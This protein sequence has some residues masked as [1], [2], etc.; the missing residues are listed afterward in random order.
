MSDRADMDSGAA[1]RA[2]A[3]A[4]QVGAATGRAARRQAARY[5]IAMGI[6]MAVAV[7]AS[8]LISRWGGGWPGGARAAL[9]AVVWGAV[10]G[11]ILAVAGQQPVRVAVARREV[12][13]LG[14][15][16]AVV[17]G[18]TMGLGPAYAVAYPIG[19]LLAFAMWALG[20]VRV[21]G[22]ARVRR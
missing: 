13:V 3:R 16:S 1:Q 5:L 11:G 21:L 22:A 7:F 12:V 4:D 9:I 6:G 17:V 18:A 10:V 14:A 2:L 15:A 8:G 19:A 20:A